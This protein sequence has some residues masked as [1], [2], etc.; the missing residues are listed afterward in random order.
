[1]MF[2]RIPPLSCVE[3]R[4]EVKILSLQDIVVSRENSGFLNSHGNHVVFHPF[5]VGLVISRSSFYFRRV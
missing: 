5:L 1:M 2:P 3:K 4:K